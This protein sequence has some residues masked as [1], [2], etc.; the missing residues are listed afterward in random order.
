MSEYRLFVEGNRPPFEITFLDASTKEPVD[1]TGQTVKF[2]YWY[3][4]PGDVVVE[5]VATV[6]DGPNGVAEYALLNAES[7]VAGVFFYEWELVD[8]NG[9]PFTQNRLPFRRTV[10]KKLGA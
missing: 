5:R 6:T 10:R 8:L 9:K 4:I 1:I 3:G 7:L 2:R